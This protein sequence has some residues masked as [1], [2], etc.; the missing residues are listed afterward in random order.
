MILNYIK[1]HGSIIISITRN[2]ILFFDKRTFCF[3]A[4]L[5]FLFRGFKIRFTYIGSGFYSAIENDITTFF[6][7]NNIFCLI[8]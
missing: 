7:N 5:Y 6:K 8:I 3:L 2:T 1:F 4:N